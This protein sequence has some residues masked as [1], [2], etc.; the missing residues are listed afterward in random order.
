ME[1]KIQFVFISQYENCRFS[2]I[3]LPNEV[4]LDFQSQN[5]CFIASTQLMTF[6]TVEEE[7]RILTY[8]GSMFSLPH[9]DFQ[10][11]FDNISTI[12]TFNFGYCL[13]YIS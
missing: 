6:C 9:F 13:K 11:K 5:G 4:C 10:Y 1:R 7:H 3:C 2:Q 12:F 8:T